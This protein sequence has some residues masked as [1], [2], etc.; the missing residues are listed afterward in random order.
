MK[1][2]Y[3]RVST[4]QQNLNM[5]IDALI[6]AGIKEKDIY[7]DK[8]S[9]KN[10][11]RPELQNCL[12]T[13]RKDD[14]LIVYKLDRLGRS[15]KD[16]INIVNQLKKDGIGFKVL[17]GIDIDTTTPSGQLIFE[18]FSALSSYER[19]LIKE[20]T[21]AGLA[22]ARA[23]GIKG[24]RKHKVTKSIIR[25]LQASMGHRDTV[26]A[27]LAKELNITTATIYRY[28]DSKGELKAP[29]IALLEKK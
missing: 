7:V 29:A 14:T 15:T 24:G 17:T 28:V 26:V 19:E 20:R 6:N 1:I 21:M 22:S 12:K 23:R 2:G 5:Q 11:D 16:L 18:I 10:T 9:G 27:E 4:T 25:R 3:A 13:L 8:L